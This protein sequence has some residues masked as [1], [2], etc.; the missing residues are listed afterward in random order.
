M[1]AQLQFLIH[2]EIHLN[3]KFFCRI[4]CL[5]GLYSNNLFIVEQSQTDVE[6][7][8]LAGA[9]GFCVPVIKT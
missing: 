6:D 1:Y 9:G 2:M 3:L 7:N 4:K 5:F 8:L